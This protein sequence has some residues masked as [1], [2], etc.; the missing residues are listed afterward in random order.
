MNPPS[1]P[2]VFRPRYLHEPQTIRYP[3]SWL[4]QE[5]A[6]G[7]HGCQLR[8]DLH[9]PTKLFENPLPANLR[10]PR[11][12]TIGFPP[13]GPNPLGS[14]AARRPPADPYR[15]QI[16]RPKFLNSWRGICRAACPVRGAADGLAG[17]GGSD[18]GPRAQPCLGAIRCSRSAFTSPLSGRGEDASL[19]SRSQDRL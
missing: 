7:G 13:P 10:P 18:R 5:G 19:A 17:E 6:R 9:I 3:A 1:S 14:P 15:I 4:R 11:P 16:C 2:S 12:P 8:M